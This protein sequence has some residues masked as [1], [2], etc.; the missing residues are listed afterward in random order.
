MSTDHPPSP[1]VGVGDYDADYYRLNRNNYR[2]RFEFRL[3]NLWR[4]LYVRAAFRPTT[5]LDVGGGMGLLVE[6][7]LGWGC[8]ARGVE[9]SHYAITQAPEPVR[10]CFIQ[11]TMSALPF[12]DRSFDVVV[13]V[14]VMEH[15][16]PDSVRP[17]LRECARV[18]RRGMYH[19]IT[20]LE[21][22]TVIHRDS[23]HHTKLTAAAW[24]GLL[25]D[26]LPGWAPRRGLH[27]PIYK[28]GIFVLKRTPEALT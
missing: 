20:V 24:L 18:A 12:P 10:R 28:N 5:V 26:S 21:D 8:R 27:I 4:A 1:A 17:A 6:R 15:L 9:L 7:L 16:D 23:T 25:S 11:G 13:S 19:E 3:A 22:R 14:N 2:D